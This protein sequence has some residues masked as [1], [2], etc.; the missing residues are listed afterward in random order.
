[1]RNVTGEQIAQVDNPDPFASPV[2]RSPVYRTP[3]F[4][5]WLV[6]LVRLVAR[7][8][9]FVLRHP[10]VD[11]VAGLVALVWLHFGWPGV[12]VLASVVLA[13]LV[14][15]RAWRP[16]WFARFVSGP[17]RNRWRWWFYRR[18]WHAVMTIA[19]L[20]PLYR[21]RVVVPLLGRVRVTGC[22]DLVRVKLVSGQSPADF[23]ARA[24]G[25]AHGF[26]ARLCR[27]R[28]AGPGAVV[29]E[30]VRRDAL[31]EPMPALAIPEVTDLRALPVGR[32]EDGSPFAIRLQGTHLLI[33]GATGAG[34]GSYLWGLVRALLPA[35]A[36]G[37]VRPWACD[38][39]LMELAFGRALFDRYG[40]YAADP[41]DIADLL[42][43]AV[44]GMQ[45][46]ARRFAGKQRDHQPTQ[47]HPFVVVL[48]DEIA[49][50][51]AYQADRK[52]RERILAALA[53]LTTQ[54]RA[55]GYCVVAALQDPRKEVL[56]IRNL[57]PDKIALRLDEPSQVD[58]VLGDGARDR[59]AACDEISVNPS[60]GAGVA[61]VRLEAAPD[62]VRVR[63]AFVSDDDIRAMTAAFTAAD[64]AALVP[65]GAA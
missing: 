28:T 52:L 9:W 30:L 2:W 57:F 31:A 18:H 7:V 20:A 11:A 16:D 43:D 13:G 17:A 29:L 15:L 22:T 32:R 3:E 46:R 34:K 44:T 49:F 48:V 55:V 64:P 39:K 53:T 6:Q 19:R 8:V 42:E 61:F 65:A 63:A 60:V 33:A 23:A 62:P 47:E 41:A 50:L 14:A 10:L 27:V 56:N 37:L 36:A 12:V 25:I 45:A 40:R 1:M 4:V 35:M 59:G 21:G 58:M 5:I 51:T 54:G 26:K 38:P 24:E